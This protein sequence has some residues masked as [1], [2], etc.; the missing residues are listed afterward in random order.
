MYF[1]Y[2]LRLYG[3]VHYNFLSQQKMIIFPF[4]P[5]ICT[6][7]I[8]LYGMRTIINNV[9]HIIT[10]IEAFVRRPIL[11]MINNTFSAWDTLYTVWDTLCT[12]KDDE[13]MKIDIWRKAWMSLDI[14]AD[15]YIYLYRQWSVS[16]NK[17]LFQEIKFCFK[18]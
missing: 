9:T 4:P 7:S 5:F 3:C 6:V 2:V 11:D 8:S 10:N 15:I 13:P 12:V 14:I 17:V 16:G 1:V 18:K